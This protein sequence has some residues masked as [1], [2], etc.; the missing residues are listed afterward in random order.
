VRNGLAVMASK[1][2]GNNRKL[3]A[4]LDGLEPWGAYRGLIG[5]IVAN[6]CATITRL[7]LPDNRYFLLRYEDLVAHPEEAMRRIG[8]FLGADV[9]PALQGI[10][11]D[12]PFAVG[13]LVAGNRLVQQGQVRLKRDLPRPVGLSW[14]HHLAYQVLAWPMRIYVALA[15]LRR[16]PM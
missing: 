5:W 14:H 2:A 6:L 16:K 9:S 15:S 11:E 13:H 1:H 12:R 4:G 10:A 7:F 3:A 8:D